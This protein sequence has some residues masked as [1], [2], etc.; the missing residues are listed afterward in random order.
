[1][2][3][4]W[5]PISSVENCANQPA[6]GEK[7]FDPGVPAEISFGREADPSASLRY[8]RDDSGSEGK[9]QCEMQVLRL[10]SSTEVFDEH[11]ITADL[12]SL[13]V[14]NQPLIR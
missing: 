7:K 13:A 6:N 11:Q 5:E 9:D 2:L 8:G 1:M 12:V 3:L 10:S 14:Q 4:V